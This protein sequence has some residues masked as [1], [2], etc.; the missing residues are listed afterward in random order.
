MFFFAENEKNG[1]DLRKNQSYIF[2]CVHR[3][4]QHWEIMQLILK[5]EEYNKKLVAQ[6]NLRTHRFAYETAMNTHTHNEC[7]MESEY[8]KVRKSSA[9]TNC[10]SFIQ[11]DS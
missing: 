6:L 3:N 4:T 11:R 10:S 2:Q 5:S 8:L 7:D 9:L 1:T